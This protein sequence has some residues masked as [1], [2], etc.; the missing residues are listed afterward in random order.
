MSE[1]HTNGEMHGCIVCGTLHQLYV[2]YDAAGQFVDCLV[3]S[4]GG[5]CVPS[6]TRPLAACDRPTQEEIQRAVQRVYGEG[7][8]ED[9]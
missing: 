8:S 9:D 7:N 3:M 6:K 2:V 1:T 4:A 5:R